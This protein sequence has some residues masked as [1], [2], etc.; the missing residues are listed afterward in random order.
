MLCQNSDSDIDY[1][2]N[3]GI[4]ALAQK[5]FEADEIDSSP[6]SHLVHLASIRADCAHANE[7]EPDE[8]D[9]RRLLED[10]SDYIRGRK[11]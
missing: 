1:N 8:G 7:V 6:H 11:I 3:D 9:V 2:Y 4:S 5:L 10:T